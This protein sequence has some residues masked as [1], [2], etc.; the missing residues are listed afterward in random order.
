M[1]DV[2]LVLLV[3]VIYGLGLPALWVFMWRSMY[4]HPAVDRRNDRL[5]RAMLIVFTA[6][7]L[8]HLILVW[9]YR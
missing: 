2:W 8:T 7:A 6:A 4:R 5:L 1:T 9:R 3:T